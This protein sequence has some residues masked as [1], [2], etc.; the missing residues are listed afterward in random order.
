MRSWIAM[1]GIAA[2]LI[3]SCGSDDSNGTNSTNGGDGGTT[4]GSSSGGDGSTAS[5]GGPIGP[6]PIAGLRIFY[7]DLVSGPISSGENS[8][9]AYVTI[10]GNGFGATQGSATVTI[11]GGAADNYP[12]WSDTKITMQLGANAKTGD[13]R[14]HV[15]AKGDSNA[16]PFTV[17]AGNIYFVTSTGSDTTGDGSF[18][19]PWQTIP[20]AKNTIAAGDIAYL[21]VKQGDSL[22]QTTLDTSSSYKC[23]L[24]MSTNDGAN[25]GTADA[26]KALV[27]YPGATATI[28]DPNGQER[29]ILTPAIGAAF[30]YWV[31][32]GLTLRGN[33]EALDFEGSSEGW[34][35][36]GNDISC[37]LGTG[38]SGCV[39]GDANEPTGLAFY[40]NVVHDAA[41]SVTTVTK[42]YHGIYFGSS[43]LDIGWNVVRDGKTCRGIQFHDTGGPNEFDVHVHDNVIHDT[44]CDGINFSTMDPSKGVVEAYNNVIYHVGTGP[45]PADGSAD[46][47]GIY[48]YQASDNNGDVGSGTVS[49][50]NN[51]L[52][53]CGTETTDSSASAF[54]R[55]DEDGDPNLKMSLVNNL[56]LQKTGERYVVGTANGSNNLFFGM[57]TSPPAA[58][59]AGINSDPQLVNPTTFDFHLMAASPAIDKGIVTLATIDFD[60]NPRPQGAAFDIGAY[61][62]TK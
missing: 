32:A 36:I 15:P 26:P 52:Y 28:G 45:D 35:V 40:G 61:E 30:D 18:A 23:A 39:N 33:V 2:S 56:V 10:W 41:A 60:G 7:S 34:R 50:Y 24:G 29:G 9:G 16:V 6:S 43:H 14:V 1:T 46:Y 54:N 19:K 17:R 57:S 8:K 5:D 48:V 21:G 38:L 42:Y 3:F 4:D 22:S 49:L 62:F 31:I 12:I 13:I 58:L 25:A 44:V 47:A 59:T 51:T 11:G 27:I 37:P 20:K 55:G 53:D